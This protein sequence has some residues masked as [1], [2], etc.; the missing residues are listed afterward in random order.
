[1]DI[2]ITRLI[3]VIIA[4]F[5]ILLSIKRGFKNGLM[6]EIVTVLSGVVSLICVALILLAVSSAKEG[7]ISTMI[8]CAVC[9]IVLGIVFK[10]CKLIFTPLLG[11]ADIT[12]I[13]GINKI[14]GALLGWAEGCAVMYLAYKVMDYFGIYII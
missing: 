10:V 4:F 2:N 3:F 13:S 12:V 5:L 9:V 1:M 14:L 7:A 11:I 8:V 6:K